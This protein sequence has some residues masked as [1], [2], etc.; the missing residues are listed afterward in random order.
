[1]AGRRED[2]RSED[3]AEALRI[4]E[5]HMEAQGVFWR[6]MGMWLLEHELDYTLAQ[7]PQ[8]A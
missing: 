7:L 2:H 1:M 3:A 4:P 8:L 6:T 5:A